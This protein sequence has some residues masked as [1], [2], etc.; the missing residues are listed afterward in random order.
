MEWAMFG[1]DRLLAQATETR[2]ARGNHHGRLRSRLQHPVKLGVRTLDPEGAGDVGQNEGERQEAC[3]GRNQADDAEATKEGNQQALDDANALAGKSWMV[4]VRAYDS[5][6][7]LIKS[8]EFAGEDSIDQVKQ[9]LAD[10]L[11]AL[12]E[13][14]LLHE[15]VGASV[16]EPLLGPV[17][18]LR[19]WNDASATAGCCINAFSTSKGPMRYAALVMMS[20]LLATNQK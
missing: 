13:R 19:N 3:A 2:D 9:V 8:F 18:L 15:R 7:Q 17:P 6:L 1:D 14:F 5:T 11:P 20:S 4:G 12:D 10:K 16:L